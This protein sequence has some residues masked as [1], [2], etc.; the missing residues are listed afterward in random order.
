[1]GEGEVTSSTAF[2]LG[3]LIAGDHH[4]ALL[5]HVLTEYQ[6]EGVA[7]E[8]GVGPG[9]STRLIAKHMPV[10]GFDSFAG[11]PQDWRPE[12][13]R[14]SFAFTP[15]TIPNVRL[16]I[17]WFDATLPTFNFPDNVGLIHIDCDLY[18]STATALQF[19]DPKPGTILVFDEF[20]G[21]PN[22]EDHEQRAFREWAGKTGM[23]WDVIG[24][25]HHEQ[26]AIKLKDT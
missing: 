12:F 25:G 20:F 8:F 9:Q 14:G 23:S 26:W 10:I 19:S 13:P 21:Y 22:A 7:L 15:P 5:E 18:S 1:M 17:G 2:D 11:L 4:Y 3:P 16:V 6:P 24:H